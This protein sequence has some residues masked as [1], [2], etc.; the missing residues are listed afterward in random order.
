ML[1]VAILGAGTLGGSIAH[2]LASRDIVRTIRLIDEAPRIAAGKAL[3]IMQSSPVHPFSAVVSGAEDISSAI[4]ASIFIVAD[5][6][7]AGEWT[8]DEG[9]LLLTQIARMGGRRIVVCAAPSQHELVERGVR[10][11]GL[12]RSTIFG[13]A[14]EALASA[15]RAMLALE[16]DRSV[17]DIALT[18]MGFPPSHLVVPWED[19]TIAGLPATRVLDEPARRRVAAKLAPLWPPG[20]HA[21]AHATAEALACLAGKSRRVLSCFVAPDLEDAGRMKTVALP[22]RVSERGVIKVPLPSLS[23]NARVALDSALS[24]TL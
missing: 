21:L 18:V 24:L 16:T 13:S 8:G 14:P 12:S 1:D 23:P 10:E 15:L 22:V 5:R 7:S 19:V 11:A 6:V 4:S 17:K 9:L 20:P 3:D 2:V